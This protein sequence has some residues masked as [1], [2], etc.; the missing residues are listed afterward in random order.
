MAPKTRPK[1][2]IIP[3]VFTALNVFCGFLA[4]VYATKAN[5]S[6]VTVDPVF[7]T[8]GWLII[9]ASVFDTLDGKIARITKAY[10]EFGIEFDSLADVVSFGVAPSILLYKVYFFRFETFGVLLS[11]L[12]LLFGS[13][14]LARFNVQITGFEKHGFTGLPIPTAA[15]GI[16][17]FILFSLNESIPIISPHET[18]F[19][20]F[21]TPLV[22]FLCLLMV[23]MLP[24][25]PLPKFS[26]RK[27]WMNI[28][29]LIYLVGGITL[30]A[31][32]K[33]LVFFPLI[34]IYVFSG[35]IRWIKNI[36][37][38]NVEIYNNPEIESSNDGD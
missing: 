37:S 9:L 13:I 28:F 27:G 3:N 17:S 33:E 10:S 7:A 34:M 16:S 32:Y 14:R 22:L 26:L 20:P 30:I 18:L 38:S 25:D 29:K 21:L 6:E 24:Y 5:S 23:S 2:I 15:A 11:F 31:I 12:P 4:V 1:K 8:A 36:F 19:R 35:I